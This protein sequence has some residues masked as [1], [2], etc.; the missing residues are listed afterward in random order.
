[1]SHKET[2]QVE[3]LF[4]TALDLKPEDRAAYLTEACSGDK[5]LHDEVESLIAAF[6]GGK[7]LI[8]QSAFTLGMKVLSGS[9]NGA[10]TGKEV[11]SYRILSALGKGGMGEVYLAEDTRLGR[12]VA[13]K[14]LSSEF[15]GDNWAKR[16]LIKEAQAV[17]MLDHPN[18][19][20]VHGFE[21][22]DGYSFIVMQYIE[23]ETLAALRGQRRLEPKQISDL[24]LQIASALS[25]AHSHGIIHRDIKPQNIMVKADGSVKV[26]DFG[27]AKFVQKELGLLN[28]GLLPSHSSQMGF[29]PGTVAYMSPEQLRH[30]RLDYRTDIFSFGAV[31]YEMIGGK[32]P[33]ARDNNAE[34]ISAILASQPLSLRHYAPQTPRE[35]DRIAQRC[36]EKERSN[37]YQS[38]SELLVDLENFQKLSDGGRQRPLSVNVRAAAAAALLMLFLAVAAFVYGHLNRPHALA[39]LPITNE[40]GNRNLDYLGDGLT[41]SIIN[42]LSG[43]SKLRVKP[44]TTVSGY[45]GEKIDPQKIGHDLNVDAVLTGHITGAGDS[46]LL[47]ATLVSATD[48]S[49][50]WSEKYKIGLAEVFSLQA[51]VARKVTSKLELWSKG[52]QEKLSMAG[53][54]KNEEAFQEYFLGRACWRNRDENNIQAAIAHF[55]Q[56]IRLDP[57]YAAAYAGLADSYV[58]LN[59]GTYGHMKTK[60]AMSKAE[61]YAKQALEIDDMLPDAHTSLGVVDLRYH[62]DWKGA[63]KEFRRA[64]ELKSDYAPAHYWYSHLLT[65]TGR[66]NEAIVE[67]ELSRDLDPFS[68]PATMNYCRAFYNARD[69]DRASTCFDELIKEHPEYENAPYVLGFV[70]LRKGMYPEAIRIYESFYAKDKARAGAALGYAYGIAGRKD[71]ARKVLSEMKELYEKSK[72]SEKF[73]LAPHE[74]AL[75][76]LGLGDKENTVNWLKLAVA[77]H[78]ASASYL[79]VDPMFDSIRSDPRFAELIRILNLP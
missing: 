31:L 71:D 34:I 39:V 43:L 20:A 70:Y 13:L 59:T 65:I 74:I 77:D 56:A 47:Q 28:P 73:Y 10:M 58:L 12:K 9:A 1:M 79:G 33:F 32:N 18:I 63:E 29:I 27:L 4:H 3:D 35:L 75:I 11:G 66:I 36:L 15:I 53:R 24:A 21:E 16:Q 57:F 51:E 52:D 45:K 50:L 25:E 48:G 78:F 55:D 64:I 62:W 26:L 38:A 42:K 49:N 23:G 7:G 19:C 72:Q 8:D 76:Y 5:S 17:A 37:R 22:Y 6:E 2:Q 44:F 69:Y 41:D 40:T 60:E 30:E 61:F 46:L 54:P 14:F 68:P 67:S